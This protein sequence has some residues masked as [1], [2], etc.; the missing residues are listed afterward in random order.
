MTKIE[1]ILDGRILDGR[2]KEK[3][4]SLFDFL[5]NT[6]AS[7]T[8]TSFIYNTKAHFII[9]LYIREQSGYAHFESIC[10]DIP[11]NVASRGTIQSIL[12][13]GIKLNIYTK[14]TYPNDKRV[15]LYNLSKDASIEVN[16][17]FN[18]FLKLSEHLKDK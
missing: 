12:D 16:R 6:F 10:K 4:S 15:K 5:S 3:P 1:T 11:K 18:D 2:I 8:S 9:T 17:F 7:S 14:L 13:M